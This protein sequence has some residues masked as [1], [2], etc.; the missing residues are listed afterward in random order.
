MNTR[1]RRRGF[2][3]V[4]IMIALAVMAVVLGAT[5]AVLS[6]S[7]QGD[8]ALRARVDMQLEATNALKQVTAL[9][10][11]SGSPPAGDPNGIYPQIYQLGNAQIASAVKSDVGTP[12]GVPSLV[13]PYDWATG[14]SNVGYSQV[15]NVCGQ[16]PN[17]KIEE[18]LGPSQ[19]ILFRVAKDAVVHTDTSGTVMPTVQG[20]PVNIVN[21]SFAIQWGTELH[22]LTVAVNSDTGVSE[23]Q[24]QV[25]D[26]T[27]KAMKTKAVLARYV[28]RIIFEMQNT[29]QNPNLTPP[30][31]PVPIWPLPTGAVYAPQNWPWFPGSD[32]AKP[33]PNPYEIR[34]T[35][36][37]SKP[38]ARNPE[39]SLFNAKRMTTVWQQSSVIMRSVPR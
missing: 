36:C 7:L 19:G 16:Y 33:Y 12:S 8:D 1:A 38:D 31:A 26:Q 21:G 15:Q 10:K 27:S 17:V 2:S 18:G 29:I 37:L 24:H 39:N 11:E 20:L 6:A 23:L 25:Y 34:I 3:L 13:S 30:P 32:P 5:Y 9:L 28:S 14:P 22:S 4:E 35:L